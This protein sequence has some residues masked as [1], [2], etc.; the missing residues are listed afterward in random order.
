MVLNISTHTKNDKKGVKNTSKTGF[1]GWFFR[2]FFIFLKNQIY[3]KNVWKCKKSMLKTC[4]YP[5]KHG[6]F[7]IFLS[8]GVKTDNLKGPIIDVLFKNETTFT[9]MKKASTFEVHQKPLFSKKVKTKKHDFWVLRTSENFLKKWKNRTFFGGT[10]FWHQKIQK[11]EKP[12]KPK[13]WWY[14]EH[15][16]RK[17]RFSTTFGGVKKGV[18]NGPPFKKK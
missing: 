1:L 7:D 12:E 11:S 3:Y 10:T 4:F 8:K 15:E 2:S 9:A 14:P 16:F 18:K 6:F 13:I 5:E 17:N